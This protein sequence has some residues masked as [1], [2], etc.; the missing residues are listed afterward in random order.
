[1]SQNEIELLRFLDV[2]GRYGAGEPSVGRDRLLERFDVLW[3]RFA[4]LAEGENSAIASATWRARAA[5]LADARLALAS[6]EQQ[7]LALDPGDRA[8]AAAVAEAC[9]RWCRSCARP[10][11]AP[12]SRS[13]SA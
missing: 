11:C 2:L 9:G 4:V 7:V 1:M 10:A 5:P 3:S 12:P 13:W 8:A 6:L